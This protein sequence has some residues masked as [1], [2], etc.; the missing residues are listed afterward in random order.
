M[1][2]DDNTSAY[3]C[4]LRFWLFMAMLLWMEN[5]VCRFCLCLSNWGNK[6]Q[7]FKRLH[8]NTYC[9]V[10]W[11]SIGVD[12][13]I[14]WEDMIYIDV[15]GSQL[16]YIMTLEDHFGKYENTYKYLHGMCAAIWYGEESVVPISEGKTYLM[17]VNWSLRRELDRWNLP[18]TTPYHRVTGEHSAKW[19]L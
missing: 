2:T 8:N 18:T 1:N 3:I 15:L 7:V 10:V 9:G 16:E 4:V 6:W 11:V 13:I 12:F 5:G 19:I 14:C 17:F